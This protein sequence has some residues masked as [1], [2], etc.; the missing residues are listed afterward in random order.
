MTQKTKLIMVN[1]PATMDDYCTGNG[2]G[3]WVEVALDVLDDHSG[4]IYGTHK[5]IL[6]NDSVYFPNLTDGTTIEFELQGEKRPIMTP[7]Q[8]KTLD[9]DLMTEEE[10]LV[11]FAQLIHTR[12]IHT[13]K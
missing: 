1:I 11:I 6:R 10:R 4:N 5:G 12:Y 9:C 3:C 7:E 13:S 2:E 8:L